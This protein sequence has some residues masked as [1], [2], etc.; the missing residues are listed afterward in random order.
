[1]AELKFNWRMGDY[2][3]VACPGRLVRFHRD[4]PNET[5]DF[6]KYYR[7]GGKEYCYS[8]GYF[9]YN[10]HEPCWEMKFVGD[11]FC[12]IDKTDIVAIFE[13]LKAAYSTLEEWSR[14]IESEG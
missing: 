8:I 2:G 6:R 9:W 12:D 3:L 5:I 1:M 10:K 4:E 11:R 13:M 14:K 7:D